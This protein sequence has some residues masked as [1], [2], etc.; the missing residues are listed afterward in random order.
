MIQLCIALLI[1]GI[2]FLV[3]EMWLPGVEVFAV[4]GLIALAVSAV[5]AVV[6]VQNGWFIVVG[7]VLIIAGL[8]RYMYIFMK[9]KQLQGN[10]ILSDTLEE[11]ALEDISQL[12][13][14]EGKTLTSLRPYG[15]ADFDGLRVEVTS[16]GPMI[17]ENTKVKVIETEARKII[18]CAVEVN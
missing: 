12:V 14:K 5:L 11:P 15:E 9:R 1:I 13:G 16:N 3:L 6:F 4:T 8:L 17:K 7:Q 2:V 18:V 10:L